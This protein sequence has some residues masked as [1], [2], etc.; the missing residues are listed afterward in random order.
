MSRNRRW[1]GGAKVRAYGGVRPGPCPADVGKTKKARTSR[2]V[3]TESP[4][5]NPEYFVG[6]DLR[7]RFMQATLMGPVDGHTHIRDRQM[8]NVPGVCVCVPINIIKF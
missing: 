2:T 3:C 4:C 8:D 1:S 5:G 7:K 6:I